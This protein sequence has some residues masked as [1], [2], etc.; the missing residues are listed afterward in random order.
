MYFRSESWICHCGTSKCSREQIL[1]G[2]S[3]LIQRGCPFM[4]KVEK[5][6]GRVHTSTGRGSHRRAVCPCSLFQGRIGAESMPEFGPE[7][8]PK[9]H[10]GSEA[11][12][13]TASEYAVRYRIAFF[14][15]HATEIPH[16]LFYEVI[17]YFSSESLR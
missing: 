1:K 10:S 6:L 2:I 5:P 14:G 13:L 4:L 17:Q 9:T 12:Y 3:F 15:I 16:T 11:R 8:K 7:T